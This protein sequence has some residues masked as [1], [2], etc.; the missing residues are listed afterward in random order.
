VTSEQPE[1]FQDSGPLTELAC[2]SDGQSGELDARKK[3]TIVL[4][5]ATLEKCPLLTLTP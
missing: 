3:N 2:F 5:L 1:R 4:L